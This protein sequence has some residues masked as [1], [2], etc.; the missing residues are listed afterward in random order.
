MVR[1]VNDSACAEGT[2]APY[3]VLS[4]TADFAS[5]LFAFHLLGETTRERE[6]TAASS[7]DVNVR[8]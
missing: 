6:L 4:L 2:M 7:A 1:F 8:Q 5:D 3:R